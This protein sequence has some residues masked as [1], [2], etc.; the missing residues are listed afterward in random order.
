MS[1]IKNIVKDRINSL[2][3]DQLSLYNEI[4]SNKLLQI[5]IP[6]GAGKGYIMMADLLNQI[7]NTKNS[8]FTISSHR[9]MLNNQHLNDIF[10]DVLFPVIGKVGF[11]FVGS[12]KYDTSKFQ[13]PEFNSALLKKKLS[14]DEII[15]STTSKREVDKLVKKHIDAGRKVVILTT[16]H[17]LHTLANQKI[18]TIY[19][20]EAHTLASEDNGAKF[21]ENFDVI[22]FKRCFF[23]TAT[24]KDCRESD[25]AFLMNN[26]SV[27]GKRV[28]L[29]F[30]ECK[31][32]GYIVAPVIHIAVPSNI[33]YDVEFKSPKNM[34]R[35]AEET[36]FAHKEFIKQQSACPE[37]ISPK[38]LI[39]CP[40]VTEMWQIHK[41]LVGKI[42][43]VKICAGASR[44]DFD[45]FNHF[46]DSEGIA[47]RSEYLKRLQGFSDSDMAIVLH[48]DTMSEGIN[49][50]GFTGVEFL[51][52]K[53][54]T[55]TKTLQN[56]GRATR[57]H[58]ED[59]DKF[60]NGEIL[61]G[62]GNW[63]KPYCAVI[64]PFWDRE[65]EFTKNE[66]AKQIKGLRDKFGYDPTY[67]ISIGSDL[68]KSDKS[69]DM[70]A[71]NKK[72][73]KDKKFQLIDEIN[74][75]IELLDKEELD[76][77]EGERISKMS[78]E[79]WFNFANDIK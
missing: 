24:P 36:F 57:L 58:K 6:T 7:V 44:N 26:K 39:K 35:F 64:I 73:E 3:P 11:I 17:S 37:K 67:Y 71:Q 56:T 1:K 31:D 69:E 47:D 70:D 48:Y 54:S 9:L 32:K 22:K 19:N 12:S 2:N 10:G 74:H 42:P 65:S 79:E 8:I 38:I 63:I 15:S 25:D 18:D 34:A 46:I 61:V 45:N 62:D 20:D 27:F 78:M 30:N 55:I 43:G 23:F 72:D 4:Q 68:A 76:M 49:I 50:P 41:E 14:F 66:L 29:T 53:L 28:G 59:R 51:G 5:C 77:N 13:T 60:R 75:E 52:G 16:Y 21:K 33:N 40:G